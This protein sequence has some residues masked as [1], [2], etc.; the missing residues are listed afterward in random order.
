MQRR[1]QEMEQTLTADVL[2]RWRADVDKLQPLRRIALLAGHPRSGTTLLEQVVD[3][4]PD[5]ISAEET[6][7]MHDEAY[8]PLIRDFPEGTSILQ[9]LDSCPLSVVIH[10]RENYFRCAEMLLGEKIGGRLLLDKNPALN[11]MIPM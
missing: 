4:H 2:A 3:A 11:L 5:I 8:L 7:L 1:A 10:A 6:K 9:A